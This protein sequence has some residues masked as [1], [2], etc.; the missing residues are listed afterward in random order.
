MSAIATVGYFLFSSFFSV[1][2]FF[3]WLRFAL[4]YFRVSSLHPL[5]QTIDKFTNPV[6]QPF[7]VFYKSG[8]IRSNRYDYACLT[9]LVAAGLL[10]FILLNLLVRG[11]FPFFPLLLLQV[12]AELIV[13]PCNFLFYAIL[14][15]VIISWVNPLLRNPM[16]ELLYLFTEPMLRLAR[17][18][19]P[20]Y[21]G[22]DFSPFI[23][24]LVLQVITLFISASFPP[25]FF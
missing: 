18:L 9:A 6:V 13:Q 7:G 15:R 3:L 25:S 8:N 16:V 17:R 2:T 22:I 11:A 19:I 5:S 4:R 23:I 1:I 24:L 21:S 20:V 12:L 14:I 10:K